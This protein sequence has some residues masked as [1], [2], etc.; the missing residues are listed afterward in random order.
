[1]LREKN[2]SHNSTSFDDYTSIDGIMVGS[3]GINLVA[4]CT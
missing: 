4:K 2:A 3:E 1:M